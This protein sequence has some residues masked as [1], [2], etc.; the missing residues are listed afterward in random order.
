MK[1]FLSYFILGKQ[2]ACGFNNEFP[3]AIHV[4]AEFFV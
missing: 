4:K 2:V 1:A 3:N